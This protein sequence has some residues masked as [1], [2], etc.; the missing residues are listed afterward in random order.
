MKR[1]VSFTI[2]AIC[3]LLCAECL[4]A[5]N[6]ITYWK[7]GI[8]TIIYSPDSIFFWNG[9]NLVPDISDADEEGGNVEPTEEEQTIMQMTSDEEE[10]PIVTYSEDD[11]LRYDAMAQEVLAVFAMQS[12]PSSRRKISNEEIDELSEEAIRKN[13]KNIFSDPKDGGLKLK[14]EQQNWNSGIWGKTRY[15]G[16]ETYYNTFSENGKRYLLVVFR[17]ESGEGFPNKKT[18][19]LKLGQVNSGKIL[20]KKT[21]YPSSE[22]ASLVVCIS[23]YLPNDSYGCVNFF[24]LLI[25]EGSNARN[26][27]NPLFVKS[28]PIVPKGWADLPYGSIFGRINGITVRCNTSDSKNQGVS[29]DYQCVELCKRYVTKIFPDIKRPY[30]PGWGNAWNWPE[31]RGGESGQDKGKYIVFANG[32]RQVREGDLIV[33]RW[34]FW[35][36]KLNNGNGGWDWTGHIGVV[37]KT[38][39]DR[40]SIAHQNGGAGEYAYPIGTRL[41]VDEDRVVKDYNPA[42]GRSPIY[43]NNIKPITHFIRRYHSSE[44]YTSYTASLRASTTNME[45][46]TV[47]VGQSKTMTFDIK[48]SGTSTL[49]I[50]SMSLTK[51]EAFSLDASNCTIGQ[52]ETRTFTVTFTPTKAEEFKDRIFI[53]SNAEDNPQ[54]TIQLSGTGRSS[55]SSCPDDNHPHVIDLGLPSGTKWCCCNVGSNTPEGFGYYI[56]W[57]E[58]EPKD[59]YWWSTL[60]YCIGDDTQVVCSTITKYCTNSVYG[61]NGY[62]DTLAELLPEDDA[63]TMNM[64]SCW[65]TP[66]IDQINELKNLE[67]TKRSWKTINGVSG[68]MIQSKINGNS[69]FL[70]AAGYFAISNLFELMKT[71]VYLSRSL[72]T[73]LCYENS[74]LLFWNGYTNTDKSNRWAGNS[75]RAVYVNE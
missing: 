33:G 41:L 3:S 71:G 42:I 8:P 61:Y 22:Y 47:D 7:D 50:S 56:A 38:E 26:Y 74:V 75:V 45:F 73:T 31:N 67:Y 13:G 10:A 24:P 20:A 65:Q 14:I 29:G 60:K 69:I 34:Q 62:T 6:A 39:K 64:G 72:D 63:A 18:A 27:I 4:L 5:Q 66:N 2:V 43:G 68:L 16:F 21:I 30:G 53:Q 52:G 49:T 12:N 70:P 15:G 58:T 32:E 28:D 23:D 44:D 36:S 25:T 37:I 9:D 35:N 19:Y 17:S 40:I 51:G 57:G 59:Y 48:N 1:S 46:G 55:I 54:W 11:S